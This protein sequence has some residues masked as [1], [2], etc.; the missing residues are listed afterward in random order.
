MAGFGPAGPTA[1]TLNAVAAVELAGILRIAPRGLG[2]N[3]AEA[4]YSDSSWRPCQVVSWARI[5][6]GLAV[7]I[8]WPDRTIG[9]YLYDSLLLRPV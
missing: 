5:R 1:P 2:R 7:L 8:V 4:L 6:G 3:A 9:W